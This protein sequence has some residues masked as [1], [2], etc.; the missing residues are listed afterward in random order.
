MVSKQ[1]SLVI[2]F[3][4][5]VLTGCTHKNDLLRKEIGSYRNYVNIQGTIDEGVYTYPNNIFKFTV[6]SLME[7]G[8][9]ITDYKVKSYRGG[10]SFTDDIG[11]LIRVEFINKNLIV[12]GSDDEVLQLSSSFLYETM[13]KP[14]NLNITMMHNEFI[15]GK[16]FSVFD[17]PNGSSM[18]SNGKRLNAIRGSVFFIRGDNLFIITRQSTEGIPMHPEYKYNDIPN[19][20]KMLQND[21]A[22]IQ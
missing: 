8:M 2:L 17:F 5:I 4:S 16:L 10:V 22:G 19:M 18:S 6:P 14:T 12:D 3:I 1:T 9:K 15:D 13:Y 7:P 21:F 20:I 11:K